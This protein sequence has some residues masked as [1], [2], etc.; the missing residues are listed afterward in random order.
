MI[1][2]NQKA[3]VSTSNLLFRSK[4]SLMLR[5]L[6]LESVSLGAK[7]N[8]KELILEHKPA[9][10]IF[11]LSREIIDSISAIVELRSSEVGFNG[12]ILCFGPHVA[13]ELLQSAENSG[14]DMVIPNSVLSAKGGKIIEKLL[15]SS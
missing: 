7:A 3:L 10:I 4:L 1:K 2:A 12:A 8:L 9:I 11:D 6:E 13:T 15:S 5:A 14:A